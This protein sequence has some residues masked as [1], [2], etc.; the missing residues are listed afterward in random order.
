[1]LP[2]DED[3]Y[4]AGCV[5]HPSV[6]IESGR[7][8]K[9]EWTKSDSL[10]HTRDRN[11][12]CHLFASRAKSGRFRETESKSSFGQ[13]FIATIFASRFTLL[14][15]SHSFHIDAFELYLIF[16]QQL[17]VIALAIHTYGSIVFKTK[18]ASTFDALHVHRH[19]LKVQLGP[20]SGCTFR[21]ISPIELDRF[22]TILRKWTNQQIHISD[23]F[24]V[25]LL[26]R[27]IK[28]ILSKGKFVHS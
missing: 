13:F 6:Q 27:Y 18:G 5:A 1:M 10:Y 9:D 26:Q 28:D 12:L 25:G 2:I 8:S 20:F 24:R 4:P 22:F 14:D 23:S 11:M 17:R 7:Q 16:A 3:F 19:M 21:Q 15:T